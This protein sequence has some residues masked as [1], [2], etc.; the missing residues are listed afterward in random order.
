MKTPKTLSLP[1]LPE[2][3]FG[4]LWCTVYPDGCIVFQIGG[5]EEVDSLLNKGGKD[6]THTMLAE[7][8]LTESDSKKLL[9][10][11]ME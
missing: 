6:L 9:A 1:V 5:T 7:V 2:S 10:F 4:R 3:E 8:G 11:L